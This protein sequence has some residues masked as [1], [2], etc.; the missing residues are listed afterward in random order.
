MR[1]IVIYR[2]NLG[3]IVLTVANPL[4]YIFQNFITKACATAP[5]YFFKERNKF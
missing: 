3:N 2:G 4:G 1:E 5:D